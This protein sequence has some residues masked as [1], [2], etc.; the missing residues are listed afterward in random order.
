MPKATIKT[1]R[2]LY[3]LIEEFNED[4]A[5]YFKEDVPLENWE[6]DILTKV[7]EL[8]KE[9]SILIDET[10]SSYGKY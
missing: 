5:E 3:D 1:A 2:S 10:D 9:A 4:L 7:E 6:D 8:R